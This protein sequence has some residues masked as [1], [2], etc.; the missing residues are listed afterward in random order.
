MSKSVV[1]YSCQCQRECLWILF[2]ICIALEWFN[3]SIFSV[4][5]WPSYEPRILSMLPMEFQS[6][7][8]HTALSPSPALQRL[9]L[10]TKNCLLN[11]GSCTWKN[12]WKDMETQT[13]ILVN[14]PALYEYIQNWTGGVW[15]F[16]DF[17]EVFYFR[18]YLPIGGKFCYQVTNSA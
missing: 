11:Y 5:S 7:G 1:R 13:D 6:P 17:I 3:T 8:L 9:S 2:E 4:A 14:Q 18:K 16:Y 15:K 12:G 10:H